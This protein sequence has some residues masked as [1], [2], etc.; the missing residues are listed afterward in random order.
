MKEFLPC[1]KY[2]VKR[3]AVLRSF[4]TCLENF[5]RSKSK[6]ENGSN[7]LIKQFLSC[8]ERL[9]KR[10][11]VGKNS[12]RTAQFLY[13]FREICKE[14]MQGKKSIQPLDQRILPC[15]VCLGKRMAVGKNLYRSAA[16][17]CFFREIR[18]EQKRERK[19]INQ[20]QS[21]RLINVTLVLSALIK[22]G[23]FVKICTYHTALVLYFFKRNL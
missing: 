14:Q 22:E 5:V 18:K 11:A 16:F 15:F 21:N 23:W 17:L 4:C 7:R 3:S 20:F 2:L 19:F 9:G 6:E 13:F 10:R 1:F 12:Y 8:F